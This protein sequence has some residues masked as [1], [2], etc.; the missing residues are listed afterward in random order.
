MPMTVAIPET[1]TEA[2]GVPARGPDLLMMIDITV[3]VEADGGRRMIDSE[4]VARAARRMDADEATAPNASHQPLHRPKTSAID[5]R[6]S[7]SNL[8]P[9]YEPRS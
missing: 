3:P 4:S 6:S 9:D 1:S 8:P 2:V 7:F 5:A